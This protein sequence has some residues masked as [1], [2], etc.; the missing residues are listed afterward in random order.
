VIASLTAWEFEASIS[1]A[2]LSPFG[3]GG[4]QD[5]KLLVGV[6]VAMHTRQNVNHPPDR[7]AIHADCPH[8]AY[9]VWVG[10][11]TRCVYGLVRIPRRSGT[12]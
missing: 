6:H 5:D 4:A 7:N 11:P 3:E 8:P 2:K 9:N 1:P 12:Q 10:R